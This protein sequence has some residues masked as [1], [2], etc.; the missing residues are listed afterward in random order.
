VYRLIQHVRL[1]ICQRVPTV[2]KRDSGHGCDILH[3]P[4]HVVAEREKATQDAGQVLEWE[5]RRVPDDVT[6]F[7]QECLSPLLFTE[8]SPVDLD[9]AAEECVEVQ[10]E[11]ARKEVTESTGLSRSEV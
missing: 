8:D 3:Q 7:R 5:L 4:T 11:N 1:F 2:R 10:V 6:Q 9:R